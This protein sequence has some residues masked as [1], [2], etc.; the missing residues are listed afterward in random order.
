MPRVSHENGSPIAAGRDAERAFI[1]SIELNPM[2]ELIGAAAISGASV[3]IVHVNSVC[4][5]DSM[6]CIEM[7]RGA[8]QRGLD[9]TTEAYP[10]TVAMTT[11]N[12]AYFNAGW[13]EKRGLD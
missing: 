3:H 12:S 2:S 10:Y 7:I 4:M 5:T 8:S 1:R 11:I 13:R 9:V 6:E